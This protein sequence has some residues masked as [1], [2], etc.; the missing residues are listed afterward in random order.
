MFATRARG[1]TVDQL[2]L[3]FDKAWM[4]EEQWK[5]VERREVGTF[6]IFQKHS[7]HFRYACFPATSMRGKWSHCLSKCTQLVLMMAFGKLPLV[8]STLHRRTVV[9]AC[10][11][12]N[13]HYTCNFRQPMTGLED[14]KRQLSAFRW[15]NHFGLTHTM[16][17]RRNRLANNG[18]RVATGRNFASAI[19]S[20]VETLAKTYVET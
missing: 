4:A 13:E 1:L 19:G 5:S 3:D 17:F 14:A 10:R 18:Q 9:L 8:S 6:T 12:A 2:F 11:P 7:Y 20:T 16:F 15:R